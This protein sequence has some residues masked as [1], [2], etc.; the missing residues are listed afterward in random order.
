MAGVNDFLTKI[1]VC[2]AIDGNAID[3]VFCLKLPTP[4]TTLSPFE[5][6]NSTGA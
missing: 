4:T 1:A 5:T 2:Y 6:S 3:P